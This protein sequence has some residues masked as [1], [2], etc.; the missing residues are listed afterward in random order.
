MNRSDEERSA[1]PRWIESKQP[2]DAAK[3]KSAA[4]VL[5]AEPLKTSKAG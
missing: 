1:A 4:S 5:D 3:L 2:V